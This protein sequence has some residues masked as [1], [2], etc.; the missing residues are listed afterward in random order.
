MRNSAMPI[1]MKTKTRIRMLFSWPASKPSNFVLSPQIIPEVTIISYFERKNCSYL[2]YWLTPLC[3][4]EGKVPYRPLTVNPSL[5]LT[6]LV[7]NCCPNLTVNTTAVYS[8][9]HPSLT[10]KVYGHLTCTELEE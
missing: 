7:H 3:A 8:Q 5:S 1:K 2:S 6:A 9:E 10:N 4:S